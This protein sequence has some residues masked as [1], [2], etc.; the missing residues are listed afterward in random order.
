VTQASY[1]R[2]REPEAIVARTIPINEAIHVDLNL[3]NQV[4]GIENLEGPVDEA[5]LRL[6]LLHTPWVSE[7][8]KEIALPEGYEYCTTEGHNRRHVSRAMKPVPPNR[9]GMP[10]RIGTTLCG[11]NA[12]DQALA[13]WRAAESVLRRPIDTMQ[14]CGGCHRTLKRLFG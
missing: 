12:V 2:L 8:A 3:D 1:L 5:A 10:G 6:V 13:N 11:H 9:Q 7:P 14:V 4:V